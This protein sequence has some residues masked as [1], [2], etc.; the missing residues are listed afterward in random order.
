[1]KYFVAGSTARTA[2]DLAGVHRNTAVRFFHILR[3]A[4]AHKK[5]ERAAPFTGKIELDESYFGSARKGKRGRSAAGQVTVIQR[6]TLRP[7]ALGNQHRLSRGMW[8]P[9]RGLARHFIGHQAWGKALA[10]W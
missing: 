8:W 2:V 5:Q 7:Q 6:A 3:S 9:G 1:M 10:E 4:V